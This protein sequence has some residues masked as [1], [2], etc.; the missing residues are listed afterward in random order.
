ML[1]VYFF[2]EKNTE[3]SDVLRKCKCYHSDEVKKNFIYRTKN[4][5]R[6]LS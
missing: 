5:T 6:A 3:I 4:N 1:K 2:P